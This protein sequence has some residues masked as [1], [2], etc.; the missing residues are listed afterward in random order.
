MR[1][2]RPGNYC[3]FRIFDIFLAVWKGKATIYCT[4]NE[5]ALSTLVGEK[6]KSLVLGIFCMGGTFFRTSMAGSIK[7]LLGECH[8]PAHVLIFTEYSN[9]KYLQTLDKTMTESCSIKLN[10]R[11]FFSIPGCKWWHFTPGTPVS[12]LRKKYNE[13]LRENVTFKGWH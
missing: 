6:A 7:K 12:F 2:Y 5:Y 1:C 11:L 13:I 4:I 3:L 8:P 10:F 9:R